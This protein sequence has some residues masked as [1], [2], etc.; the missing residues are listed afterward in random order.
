MRVSITKCTPGGS[1]PSSDA[2]RNSNL[3]NSTSEIA[4]Q[5]CQ[6]G[7]TRPCQWID[8]LR[9]RWEVNVRPEEYQGDF[10]PHAGVNELIVDS[11]MEHVV[12]LCLDQCARKGAIDQDSGSRET[13][14]RDI[15]VDDVKIEIHISSKSTGGKQ[16]NGK[17][18]ESLG[19]SRIHFRT[20]NSSESQLVRKRALEL[21]SYNMKGGKATGLSMGY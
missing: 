15:G 2:V 20:G 19:F 14:W 4:M 5:M 1:R 13:I 7:P 6:L 11:N 10:I 21:P 9:L 3:R 8:V 18:E 16:N 17:E 12:F